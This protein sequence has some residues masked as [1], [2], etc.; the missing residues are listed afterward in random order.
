MIKSE[1]VIHKNGFFMEKFYKLDVLLTI[2][3]KWRLGNEQTY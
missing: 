2:K 3:L 1:R